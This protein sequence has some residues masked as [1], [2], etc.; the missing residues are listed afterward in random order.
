MPAWKFHVYSAMFFAA[1]AQVNSAFKTFEDDLKISS[2]NSGIGE[3]T[4][5]SKFAEEGE[6]KQ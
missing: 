1:W 5:F 3:C 2:N 6:A 4:K